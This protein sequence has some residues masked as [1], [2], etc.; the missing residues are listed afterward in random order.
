MSPHILIRQ[1]R[2]LLEDGY[3]ITHAYTKCG[4]N[5]NSTTV[6]KKFYSFNRFETLVFAARARGQVKRNELVEDAL[7]KKLSEG[8]G[9]AS[10]YEF[11]LTQR[12]PERWKKNIIDVPASQSILERLATNP[13]VINYISVP[14]SIENQHNQIVQIKQVP[15]GESVDRDEDAIDPGEENEIQR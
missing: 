11:Y 4:A 7:F 14:V 5:I 3:L 1:F 8:K 2:K 15:G 12:D 9:S 10:E 13:P 6:L